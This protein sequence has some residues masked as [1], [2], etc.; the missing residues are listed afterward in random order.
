MSIRAVGGVIG[1][2]GPA[3]SLTSSI[4]TLRT[5]MMQ[6]RKSRKDA[7]RKKSRMSGDHKRG[8]AA[9]DAAGGSRATGSGTRFSKSTHGPPASGRGG[10]PGDRGR[11]ASS[12]AGMTLQLD[13][14]DWCHL[15]DCIV[16]FAGF[17]NL[18]AA[19]QLTEMTGDRSPLC[20]SS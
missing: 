5:L 15:V 2:G 12:G 1:L 7:E 19:V 8:G 17:H 16:L 18:A 4:V 10:R 9:G 6:V 13:L 3:A 11:G 20:Y 14:T